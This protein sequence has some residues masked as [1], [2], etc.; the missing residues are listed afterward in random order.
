MIRITADYDTRNAKVIRRNISR[1]MIVISNIHSIE[2]I[3]SWKKGFHL[4]IWSKTYYDKETIFVIRQLI[5]DDR[6]RIRLDRI[7][8][9]GM[10]TLF[11]RKEPINNNILYG[12]LKFKSLL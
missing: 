8:K 4:I 2:L 3:K 12:N 11:D 6:N 10:Q 7:R 5:G 9:K 1:A